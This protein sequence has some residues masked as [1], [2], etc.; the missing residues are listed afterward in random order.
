MNRTDLD[1]DLDIISFEKQMGDGESIIYVRRWED[2]ISFVVHGTIPALTNMII[3]VK[4]LHE[5]I[6]M[7]AA[8]L[9]KKEGVDI[10]KYKEMII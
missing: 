9:T 8:F 3:D 1:L 2:N 7:A 4:Q 6:M 10:E 5:P